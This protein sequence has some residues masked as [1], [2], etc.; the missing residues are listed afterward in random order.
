[1][2]FQSYAKKKEKTRI[3][4]NMKDFRKVKIFFLLNFCGCGKR[5]FDKKSYVYVNI[6]ITT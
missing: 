3:Y 2:A 4:I 1:M 6:L 5:H